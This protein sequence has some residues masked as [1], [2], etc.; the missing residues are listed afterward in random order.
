MAGGRVL[1]EKCATVGALTKTVGSR[2]RVSIG[3]RAVKSASISQ[4]TQ[5]APDPAGRAASQPVVGD[6]RGCVADLVRLA[7]RAGRIGEGSP[8]RAL[9]RH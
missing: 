7:L 9:S 2:G 4:A 8:G 5:R 6:D 1:P 3:R